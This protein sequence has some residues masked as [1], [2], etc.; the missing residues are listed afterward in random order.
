MNKQ[1]K[2]YIFD[3]DGTLVD[4]C[5]YHVKA[6]RKFSKKH[7]HEL[8]EREILDWMGAQGGYYIERIMGKP[9]P[10]EEVERLCFEKEEIYRK[11]YKP[12]KLP[13]ALSFFDKVRNHRIEFFKRTH[14]EEFDA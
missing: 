1:I 8:T 10:K 13:S 5:A 11:I 2:A 6:W 9:L 3:M 12:K 4:N 14:S 7:G